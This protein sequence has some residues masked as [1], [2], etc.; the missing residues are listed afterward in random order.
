[1][2]GVDLIKVSRMKHLMERWGTQG[3]SKFLCDDEIALVKNPNNAAGFWAA[4]EACSKALGC[5]IGSECGFHDILLSKTSR[6]DGRSMLSPLKTV[7]RPVPSLFIISIV[8][9][10]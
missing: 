6:E 9:S 7:A 8:L 5:G 10:V 4:K 2:I 3:L 1:M